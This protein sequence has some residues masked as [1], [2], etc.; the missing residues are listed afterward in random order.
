MLRM[1]LWKAALVRGPEL[2][3]TMRPV[4]SIKN[5]VGVPCGQ[6]KVGATLPAGDSCPGAARRARGLDGRGS[7]A[8]D[9]KGGAEQDD[10]R[11]PYG[12]GHEQAPGACPRP[13]HRTLRPCTLLP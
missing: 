5:A 2:L 9:E 3:V 12:P 10:A 11:Q 1:L 4:R 7:G 8:C 13:R 6:G